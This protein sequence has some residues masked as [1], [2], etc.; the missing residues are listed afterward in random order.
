MNYRYHTADEL[1]NL[2]ENYTESD[3]DLYDI[4]TKYEDNH[5][6]TKEKPNPQ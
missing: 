2:E 4:L 6:N 3:W 5:E 1:I